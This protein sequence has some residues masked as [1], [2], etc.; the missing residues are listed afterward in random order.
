MIDD[1]LEVEMAA[2][3]EDLSVP[4]IFF[5]SVAHQRLEQLKDALWRILHQD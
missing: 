5:S 1:E 3:L 2:E 4:Y